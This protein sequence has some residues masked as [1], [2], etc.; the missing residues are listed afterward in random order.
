MTNDRLNGLTLINMHKD[1]RINHN[2][3]A[4]KYIQTPALLL[5][6]TDEHD[7]ELDL[8]LMDDPAVEEYQ[9]EEQ[10]NFQDFMDMLNEE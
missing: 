3:I 2:E 4:N 6:I 8:E 9:G 1:V 7:A 5:P 10:N